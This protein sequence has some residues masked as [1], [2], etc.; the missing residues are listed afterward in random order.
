LDRVL[1][2][3]ETELEELA[4]YAFGAAQRIRG[5]HLLNQ[6]HE[7]LGETR[8]TSPA[9]TREAPEEVEPLTGPAKE[10]I[11]LENQQPLFPVLPVAGQ[12]EKGETVS[13]G[14]A[15][16]LDMALDAQREEWLTQEGILRDEIGL[17]EVSGEGQQQ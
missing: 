4:V 11:G 5:G 15:W 13:A 1:G 3:G 12:E 10:R 16:F 2:H 6:G 17:G 7:V 8:T 9:A 14:E